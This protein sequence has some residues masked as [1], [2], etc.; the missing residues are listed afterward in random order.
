MYDNIDEKLKGL[1]KVLFI[2]G[3]IASAVSGIVIMKNNPGVSEDNTFIITGLMV[4]VFGV[5]SSLFTSWV[6]Y[7]IGENISLS[8]SILKKVC[9]D[10][11][12][13]ENEFAFK[14]TTNNP[15]AISNESEVWGTNNR[16]F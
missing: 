13:K 8:Y 11:S 16:L 4:I 5:I 7:G 10:T 12:T 14:K 1:A 15:S 3:I 6:I 2:V 9:K